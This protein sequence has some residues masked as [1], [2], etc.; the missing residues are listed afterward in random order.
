MGLNGVKC[1]AKIDKDHECIIMRLAVGGVWERDVQECWRHRLYHVYPCTRTGTD[2]TVS[3]RSMQG[4][5]LA[6][7]SIKR[8]FGSYRQLKGSRER[9]AFLPPCWCHTA[10]LRRRRRRRRGKWRKKRGGKKES[11]K[12]K[13]TTLFYKD[14]S[15]RFSQNL[16]N[17]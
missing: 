12:S 11:E 6:N 4:C 2:Q 17:N 9:N 10:G 15:F 3:R 13:S 16:P 14:C 7:S 1:W 5:I 8:A